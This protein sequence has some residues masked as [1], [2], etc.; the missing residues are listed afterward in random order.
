MDVNIQKIE[1]VEGLENNKRTDGQE[2][3]GYSRGQESQ[4]APQ[5]SVRA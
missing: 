2:A 1:E 4:D 5:V 3:P